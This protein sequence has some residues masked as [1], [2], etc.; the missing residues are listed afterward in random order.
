VFLLTSP[1]LEALC[2]E[3]EKYLVD[4]KNVRVVVHPGDGK[5]SYE[6]RVD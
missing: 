2:N 5:P 6:T 1:E 3:S 4:G